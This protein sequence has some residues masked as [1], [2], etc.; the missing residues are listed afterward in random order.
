M[1][2]RATGLTPHAYVTALRMERARNRLESGANVA[3]AAASVGYAAAHQ[4]RR[5]FRA[6]FGRDPGSLR[7]GYMPPR[8]LPNTGS[9]SDQRE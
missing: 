3:T 6:H 2:R 9:R 4:F 8:G 5:A 1:F 7:H